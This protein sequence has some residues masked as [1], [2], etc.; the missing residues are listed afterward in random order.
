MLGRHLNLRDGEDID[1]GGTYI[2]LGRMDIGTGDVVI[3]AGDEDVGAG[4]IGPAADTGLD[5]MCVTGRAP[6]CSGDMGL[7]G[8]VFSAGGKD[9]LAGGARIGLGGIDVGG[10][11]EVVGSR[12]LCFSED[13]GGVIDIC[14]GIGA[15][16]LD[17]GSG[18]I[19]IDLRRGSG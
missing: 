3:S 5:E 12:A 17:I 4:G 14:A 9:G 7:G 1:A 11:V 6:P 10:E 13:I 16:G 19:D 18:C 15:G 8:I 2:G